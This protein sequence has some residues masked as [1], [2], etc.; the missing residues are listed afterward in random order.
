MNA[1]EVVAG[2]DGPGRSLRKLRQ[3]AG[4][5]IVQAAEAVGKPVASLHRAEDGDDRQ[6]N[7]REVFVLS[8]L[9]AEELK[10]GG[11]R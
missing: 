4:V 2:P 10:K 5:P 3:L 6:L 9:Y 1:A 8:G 11:K 7:I